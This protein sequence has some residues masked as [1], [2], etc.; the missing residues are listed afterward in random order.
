MRR[1]LPLAAAG[2]L[3]VLLAAGCDEDDR[4][5]TE[6]APPGSSNATF[7]RVQQEVFTP[8]CAIPGCHGGAAADAQENM[9][10]GQGLSYDAIVRVPSRQIPSLLRVALR[11][12]RQ[13]VSRAQ[14]HSRLRD[15]PALRCPSAR[16]SAKR[17]GSSSANGS[18]AA[19][20]ATDRFR[21]KGPD[22]R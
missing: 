19:R 17:T 14:D 1:R 21:A 5:P 4:M 6:V 18:R 7:G 10:L 12:P 22:R 9:P 20:L 11:R 16:R 8:Q 15:R 2:I 3:A 13:L